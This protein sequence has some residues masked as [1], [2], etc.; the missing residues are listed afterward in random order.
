VGR[1]C[2]L[3][4]LPAWP[5]ELRRRLPHPISPVRRT[6]APAGAVPEEEHAHGDRND[7]FFSGAEERIAAAA[8]KIAIVKAPNMSAGR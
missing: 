7:R 3:R 5:T 2:G 1:P 8:G 4:S 6:L